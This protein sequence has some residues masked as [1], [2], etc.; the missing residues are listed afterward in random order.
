MSPRVFS[1]AHVQDIAATTTTTAGGGGVH[2]Y[3]ESEWGNFFFYSILS[4]R[5]LIDRGV[6]TLAHVR[7]SAAVGAPTVSPTA[8]QPSES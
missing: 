5:A 1:S 4:D 2:P 6:G 3:Y 7:G 8:K